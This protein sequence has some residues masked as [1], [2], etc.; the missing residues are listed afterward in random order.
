MPSAVAGDAG[1]FASLAVSFWRPIASVFGPRAAFMISRDGLLMREP[2][3]KA[4]EA[5]AG[6]EGQPHFAFQAD[7]EYE[8]TP[9]CTPLKPAFDVAESRLHDI[10]AFH[11]DNDKL[12]LLDAKGGEIAKLARIVPDGLEYRWWNITGYWRNGALTHSLDT[13]G[14]TPEIAFFNGETLGTPGA[15]VFFG[16]YSLDGD[17]LNADTGMACFGGC[18][19]NIVE[20][21]KVQTDAIFEAFKGDLVAKADGPDRF[22]LYDE[23][24]HIRVELSAIKE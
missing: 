7:D 1:P 6:T 19:G 15:G 23:N 17:R 20:R 11:L 16:T 8:S 3:F 5:F 21:T 4:G 2:C 18:L 24:G 12:I 22:E 9:I 10:A 14:R 13:Y